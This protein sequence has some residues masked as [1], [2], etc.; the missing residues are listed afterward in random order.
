[1]NWTNE[2][3]TKPGFYWHRK[4]G[5][6]NIINVFFVD[7]KDFWALNNGRFFKLTNLSGEF[8]GPIP[9]PGEVAELMNY[10]LTK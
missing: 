3:P 9:K 6:Y 7:N 4:N 10:D 5:F 8:A 1:M 2:K